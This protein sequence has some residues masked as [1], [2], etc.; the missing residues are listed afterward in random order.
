MFP[1]L[2]DQPRDG[3]ETGY[4][5]PPSPPPR[6]GCQ[7]WRQTERNIEGQC[8]GVKGQRSTSQVVGGRESE[9]SVRRE[10]QRLN[11]RECRFV[12]KAPGGSL[13]EWSGV[14]RVPGRRVTWERRQKGKGISWLFVPSPRACCHYRSLSRASV[15][16]AVAAPAAGKLR[17]W[18]LPPD[19]TPS[20]GPGCFKGAGL[21]RTA[22]WCSLP[23]PR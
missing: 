15:R 17:R 14:R 22:A 1:T 11:T 6:T 12:G 5:A 20:G 9:G 7:T 8:L 16:P 10:T 2:A 23:A 21:V 13:S 4:Q 18:R 3:A 19:R